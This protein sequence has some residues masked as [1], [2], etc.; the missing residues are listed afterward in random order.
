MCRSSLP[1]SSIRWASSIVVALGDE[2]YADDDAIRE[3]VRRRASFNV[4][5]LATAFKVDVFIPAEVPTTSSSSPISILQ[6]VDATSRR[7]TT[8]KTEAASRGGELGGSSGGRR[9][10]MSDARARNLPRSG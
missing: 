8:G 4:I 5:H 3:A 10:R 7:P 1:T 6:V 9:T 2:F